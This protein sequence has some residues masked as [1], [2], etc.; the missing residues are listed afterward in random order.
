MLALY[1]VRRSFL[2]HGWALLAATALATAV[3]VAVTDWGA[4]EIVGGTAAGVVAW[5][6]LAVVTEIR[7]CLPRGR[8]VPDVPS[9]TELDP[10]GR[11]RS[12][13]GALWIVAGVA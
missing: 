10:P 3:V 7:P 1:S 12:A 8:V 5:G 6:A 9:R 4:A 13:W 2:A 11:R